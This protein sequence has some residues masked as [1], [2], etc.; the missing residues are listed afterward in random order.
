MPTSEIDPAVLAREIDRCGEA[1]NGDV[2]RLRALARA[3][4]ERCARFAGLA[5]ML[6]RAARSA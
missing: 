2:S 4:P 6:A 3:A 5:E 1:S